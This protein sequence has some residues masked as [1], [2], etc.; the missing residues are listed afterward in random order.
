MSDS[1]SSGD[2]QSVILF[3][4]YGIPVPKNWDKLSDSAKH[5]YGTSFK[6][7]S[8]IGASDKLSHSEAMK[9]VKSTHKIKGGMW[10]P[11]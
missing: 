8:M 10:V 1:F 3:P 5:V 9:Q 4:S 2:P 11:K 6:V 7:A